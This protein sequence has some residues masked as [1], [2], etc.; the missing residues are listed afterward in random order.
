MK[1]EH[2]M[3]ALLIL[4]LVTSCATTSEIRS[5]EDKHGLISIN[6]PSMWLDKTLTHLQ[7]RDQVSKYGKLNTD[8]GIRFLL[9]IETQNK[10]AHCLMRELT[11]SLGEV[12][13]YWNLETLANEIAKVKDAELESNTMNSYLQKGIPV[14]ISRNGITISKSSK[15]EHISSN[16]RSFPYQNKFEVREGWETVRNHPYNNKSVVGAS[17]ITWTDVTEFPMTGNKKRIFFVS[18]CISTGYLET[19]ARRKEDVTAI[20]QSIKLTY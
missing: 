18:E 14:P 12:G 16:Q 17:A 19:E 8:S 9:Y 13:Y 7:E 10:E 1:K 11:Y 5:L 4:L 2:L 6:L 20:L 3:P 15:T